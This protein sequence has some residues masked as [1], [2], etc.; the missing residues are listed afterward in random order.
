MAKKTKTESDESRLKEK[1]AG[2]VQEKT[3]HDE[4]FRSLRKRLKRLQRKRRSR[5]AR[6][7]RAAAKP[8][9]GSA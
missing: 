7:A 9:E 1:I 2:R 5:A 3:P 8:T 6:V 4:S